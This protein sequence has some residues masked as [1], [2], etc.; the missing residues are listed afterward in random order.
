[1]DYGLGSSIA[2][3]AGRS[4]LFV[5]LSYWWFGDLS[6]LELTDG[7]SYAAG[8]SVPAFEGQGSVLFTL[9]GMS[10]IIETTDPPVSL[11]TSVGRSVGRRGF[12]SV[13]GGIGLTESAPDL[14]FQL[15]WSF[16]N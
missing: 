11:A 10:R 2:L 8:V 15:G 16:R 13:G 14:F 3:G 6:D 7:L 4:L 5:D 9:S 12:L 1:W